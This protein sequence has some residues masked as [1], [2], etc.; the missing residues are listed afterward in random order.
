VPKVSLNTYPE[1]ESVCTLR[2]ACADDE[3]MIYRWR[4]LPE[5]IELGLSRSAVGREEH[6]IWFR[7]TLRSLDRELFVIEVGGQAAGT[8]RYDFDVLG[9]AEISI[10]LVPSYTGRGFGTQALAQSLPETFVKRHVRTIRAT[11]RRGNERSLAFFHSLG[12]R[13]A[14]TN[15]VSDTLVLEHPNVPHSRPWIEHK[16]IE[17]VVSVLNSRQLSQGPCVAELERLWCKATQCSAAAAVGTG[18]GAL[19]L[20]LLA[21]GVGSG[22]EVILPSYCCVAL[23]NAAL[24]IGATPVCA[25]VDFDSWTLSAEDVQRKVTKQTKAIIAVHLFGYPADVQK[26]AAFDVPVIEDCAHGIGGT[27]GSTP[28][29]GGS[30]LSIGSFYAT[31]MLCAGEGGIV[32]S[33]HANLINLVIKSRDYSDQEAS[34]SRLNDKLTD[35]QA[36][37]AIAQLQK[38]KEILYR[39]QARARRY[40]SLLAGLVDEGLIALPLDTA[41]RIWYR[42]TIRLTRHLARKVS[43]R[44]REFSVSAELP[45]HSW[46]QPGTSDKTLPVTMEAFDRLLSLPLY[47]DLSVLEQDLVVSSLRSALKP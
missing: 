41:G 17:A 6:G 38:L 32:A 13:E 12:F 16:E 18:L 46:R 45:V 10:Y 4:N 35:F 25:D 33:P 47:P 7:E 42:Y 14:E 34:G 21:L 29:G 40:H 31:K 37:L 44:M 9:Q 23:A 5:I 3:E 15:S 36:A 43:Q 28:F 1:A 39:R 8:V 2:P 24:A 27:T 22:N 19:R 11:V 26:L 20:A 30:Q